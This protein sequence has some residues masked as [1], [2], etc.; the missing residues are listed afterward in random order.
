MTTY[1]RLA[2]VGTG[3]MGTAVRERAAAMGWEPVAVIG[4][5]AGRGGQGITRE[6][7]GSAEVAIEFTT[8]AAAASIVRSLL[9]ADCAVV[10]GTTGW[11]DELG[12][13][14]RAVR[15]SGGTLLHSPN[16]SV[17]AG[18]LALLAERAAELLAG[19]EEFEAHIVETHHA[20]KVDAPS[21]TAAMLARSMEPLLGRRVPVSS[22][23]VGAVPGTHSVILDAP[24]EQLRLE[25][26]VRDRGVFAA[27]AL[28]AARWVVGRPGFF[29]MK[30]LLSG[31]GRRG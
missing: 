2:I 24:L 30:D 8:P 6:L 14:A 10:S 1:P 22:V 16:F 18:V 13:V 23:R 19:R 9:A 3:R 27:G 25:H 12:V 11:G 4:S 26:D 20:A 29:G 28:A 7:L 31:E 15:A 5:E 21:G 17:G